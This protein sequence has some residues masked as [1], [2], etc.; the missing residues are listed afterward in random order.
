MRSLVMALTKKGLERSQMLRKALSLS[1]I[2]RNGS[3][4]LWC[5]LPALNRYHPHGRV[6]ATLE[7]LLLLF[8]AERSSG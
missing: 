1:K 2:Y 8:L 6:I 7:A 4:K 5:G 3:Q